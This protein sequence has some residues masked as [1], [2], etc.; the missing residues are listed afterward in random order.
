MSADELRKF[1]Q[2]LHQEPSE[3]R[4]DFFLVTLLTGARR[5]NVQAMCRYARSGRSFLSL[6][7]P[8]AVR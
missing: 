3:T 4:Q 5:A 8:N 7:D 6:E 2:A 1:F